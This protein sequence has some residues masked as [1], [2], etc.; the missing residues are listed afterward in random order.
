MLA[1]NYSHHI[2]K[3]LF[4]ALPVCFSQ[5]GHI[6]VGFVDTAMVGRIDGIGSRAQ[7][8]MNI[9]NSVYTLVLV[10]GL[11]ISFGL[12]PLV[13][14]ADGAKKPGRITELLR[15]AFLVNTAIGLL[16][17]ILLLFA[18]PL[19]H[20]L[21]QDPGVVEIAIPFMNVMIFS[22]VP[23]SLYSTCKQFAEGLSDTRLAMLISL[24]GNLMNVLL[25]YILIFGHWGFKP[26]G[27]MGACWGSFYARV[28]MAIAMLAYIWFKPSY[29]KYRDAFRMKDFSVP[30]MKEILGTGIPTG[31]QWVFEV[32]AFSVAGL[33][34]GTLSVEK[35]A[36][37]QVA[38]TIA[39][40]TYMFASGLSAAVSVRT[41]NELGR[42]NKIEM[43]KA[44]FTGFIMVTVFML[45]CALLFITCRHGLVSLLSQDPQVLEA[46]SGLLIIAAMFQ[47]SDGLQVIGLGALRGMNDTKF[48]TVLTLIAY[49]G[50]G[51]PCSYLLGLRFGFGLSGIWYGFVI[52]L[53]FSAIGLLWRFER[54][55]RKLT[56]T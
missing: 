53:S 6:L 44:G 35:Q 20:Y 46:A 31:L 22:L 18:S 4:L 49:W 17:F 28:F 5:L 51:L 12:T 19:L 30:T 50:V 14:A 27:V 52:G 45:S 15:N 9:T 56:F 37:H 10:F 23:L 3:T 16:L 26:M 2:R 42:K 11:G 1:K 41:G 40:C 32:G 39:A 36:A 34:A 54:V 7:A 13:A 38:L 21:K 48:P 25:N 8:A 43:R 24:S 29:R 33:M 47:L 55:S